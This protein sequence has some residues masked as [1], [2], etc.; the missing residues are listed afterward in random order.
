MRG[1]N[2]SC[3]ALVCWVLSGAG[4]GGG[5][6]H[7]GPIIIMANKKLAS[8]EEDTRAQKRPRTPLTTRQGENLG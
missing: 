8:P 2:L 6:A 4:C 1:E 3:R 7:C 5:G